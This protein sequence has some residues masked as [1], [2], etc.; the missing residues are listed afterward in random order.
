VRDPL[1]AMVARF[2]WWA[3]GF[4]RR[5]F[6][7]LGLDPDTVARLRDLEARGTVIFT[8]HYASRLDYFLMN[9]LFLR[10]GLRL[11]CLANGIR[12][13]YYG[14]L[15]RALRVRWAL[16]RCGEL[17]KRVVDRTPLSTL[18][19]EP[20]SLFVFLRT[21]RIRTWLRGRR[22]AATGERSDRRILDYALARALE[23]E[24]IYVVPVALFWRKGPRNQRRFLN[25]AY[26]APTRPSDFAKVAGFLVSYRSLAVKVGE[27]LDLGR[28]VADR[29]AEPRATWARKLRRLALVLL[30]REEKVVEGPSLR[31]R[32]QVAERVLGRARVQAAIAERAQE[33]KRSPEA[34]RRDAEKMFRE[35][36]ASMNST[37]L[38][39]L[40]VIVS[41]IFRRLFQAVDVS[42]IERVASVARRNP[43]VLVP[44]HRSYFDFMLISWLCYSH[45]LM[46][47]HIAARENMAFGPFGYIFRRAGAFFL[48]RSFDDPLYKEVFRA[49]I[50]Y[51][52]SEGFPQ[53][54]FIEGGRSRTGRTLAPKLGMLS[55][56]VDAFLDS[57]RRDL[58]LIPVS[59]SYERL[60]EEGAMLS[61]L[62]GGGKQEE[63]VLGLLKARKVLRRRWGS[64]FIY[65][66]EPISLADFLGRDRA[67]FGAE[68]IE[69][70]RI[71]KRSRTEALATEIVERINDATVV[72]ATSVAAAVFLG[73]ARPGLLRSELTRRMQACVDLLRVRGAR[74][75]PA[76]T[77]DV[78]DF[79]ESIAFLLRSD[80]I[81]SVGD[82]RGEI[83]YFDASKRPALDLYRNTILH[84]LAPA[85]FL[86]RKLLWGAPREVLHDDLAFWL[87]LFHLELFNARDRVLG[88][89]FD[90]YLA[91]FEALGFVECTDSAFRAT[92]KGR[93]VLE[94]LALQTQG[95]IEAHAAACRAAQG[96]AEPVSSRQLEVDASDAFARSALLG[97]VGS[98]EVGSRATF[99]NAFDA[100]ARR[101]I[102]ARRR[103]GGN[104]DVFYAR[105]DRFDELAPLIARLAAVL[106]D[107]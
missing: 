86:A 43:V 4:A 106:G 79:E 67:R 41:G 55:W 62:A 73:S 59:I 98:P 29:A 80:L 61:E 56:N 20:R 17:R 22:H 78:G 49:Y 90:A 53:E 63:S 28:F 24:A 71:D 74:L 94:A 70:D 100:L 65:F 35:I 95:L 72:N 64:A 76:L 30:S 16:W 89:E 42:G 51:L 52:V 14:P 77:R 26:G 18:L 103:S 11:S 69:K 46:P 32:H 15:W 105:G 87:D 107:R 48:R 39:V 2:N 38:A 102:L 10:H 97:Q 92:E 37:F 58:F 33:R 12:F 84:F 81:R 47:P 45:Y 75:T 3:R 93:D 85:S 96:I 6:R 99:A 7:D 27:P 25:L 1:S 19:R 104:R 57:G 34:A 88:S 13:D 68:A 54:F 91:H 66:G 36:A 40:G 8:M 101:G 23:G 50:S 44:N 60:V 9:A 82:P 21:E 31:P 83:L 5:F